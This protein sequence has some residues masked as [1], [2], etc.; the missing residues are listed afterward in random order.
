MPQPRGRDSL[1]GIA[2]RSH[3]SQQLEACAC[4]N[5]LVQWVTMTNFN[6]REFL[7]SVAAAAFVPPAKSPVVD[8]HMH[9]WSN[10]IARYPVAH[11]YDPK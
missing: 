10:D 7:S 9:I 11:P 3:Q 2:E 1:K 6:R 4:R 8:T 5:V